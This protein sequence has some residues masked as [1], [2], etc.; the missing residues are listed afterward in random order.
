MATCLRFRYHLPLELWCRFTSVWTGNNIVC[1]MLYAPILL[2]FIFICI[3]LVLFVFMLFLYDTFWDCILGA[4]AMVWLTQCDRS[5][6]EGY[7]QKKQVSIR[8][9]FKLKYICI[10]TY[11]CVIFLHSYQ[12]PKDGSVLCYHRLYNIYIWGLAI[13]G[14]I[15]T[16]NSTNNQFIIYQSHYQ[17]YKNVSQNMQQIH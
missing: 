9:E 10:Y 6:L 13:Y 12:L 2:C 15:S 5:K 11:V 3:S 7:V 8:T 14:Q 16:D 1:S 4:R 17:A